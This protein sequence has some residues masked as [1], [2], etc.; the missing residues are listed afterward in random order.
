M[1]N[2]EVLSI[3]QHLKYNNIYSDDV[4]PFK[5]NSYAGNFYEKINGFLNFM[6]EQLNL[7]MDNILGGQTW[8]Q[9]PFDWGGYK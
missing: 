9:I 7:Y 8:E 3:P 2:G 1:G 6:N 5:I 4:T